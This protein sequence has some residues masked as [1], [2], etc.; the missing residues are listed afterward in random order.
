MKFLYLILFGLVFSLLYMLPIFDSYAQEKK[1]FVQYINGRGSNNKTIKILE[2]GCGRR[3]TIDLNGIDY[4]LTGIDLDGKALHHRVTE[5][6]DL[7]EGIEGDLR[8][9]NL[10]EE[11]FDV[12]YNSF[13]LE[14]ID[15]AEDV[16]RKFVQWLK[17]GGI[18]I[19]RIPDKQSAFGF[20]TRLTPFWFHVFVRRYFFGN[21][22][23]GKPGFDPYPTY[24]DRVVSRKGMAEFC[25]KNPLVIREEWGHPYPSQWDRFKPLLKIVARTV[26]LL[27]FGTL[28]YRHNNLTYVLEKRPA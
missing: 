2:A 12:I 13:V 7:H 10:P 19:I 4:H 8:K 21:P 22:N 1:I 24:Y 16:L 26:Y 25:Q 20:L 17:P 6:K 23:A 5:V 14:H 9:I 3:W 15:G 27:S 18:L 11:S 28:S